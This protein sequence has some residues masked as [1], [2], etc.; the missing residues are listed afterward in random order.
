MVMNAIFVLGLQVLAP[1]HVGFTLFALFHL[2]G[3]AGVDNDAEL[4]VIGVAEEV[5]RRASGKH[6]VA[7][8]HLPIDVRYIFFSGKV[9]RASAMRR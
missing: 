7:I 3:L 4:L 9:E 8:F 6:Q 5:C 2:L 1:V